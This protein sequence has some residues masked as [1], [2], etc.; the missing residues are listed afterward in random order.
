MGPGA[1]QSFP[2]NYSQTVQCCPY[3]AKWPS[4]HCTIVMTSQHQTKLRQLIH[5]SVFLTRSPLSCCVMLASFSRSCSIYPLW[6]NPYCAKSHW[7]SVLGQV[8]SMSR[9]FSE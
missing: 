4:H 8:R 3:L 5:M 6:G 1:G 2:S 9:V 7:Q